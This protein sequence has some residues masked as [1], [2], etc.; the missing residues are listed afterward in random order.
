MPVR[1]RKL[2]SGPLML[3]ESVSYV[4]QQRMLV[5]SG[6]LEEVAVSY[7]LSIVLWRAR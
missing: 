5:G 1:V 3:N 4:S 2:R 7:R 6:C